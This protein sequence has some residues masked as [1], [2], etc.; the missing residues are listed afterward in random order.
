MGF[1]I[2]S[3]PV[4]ELLRIQELDLRML[5]LSFKRKAGLLVWLGLLCAGLFL[6]LKKGF[7]MCSRP[8]EMLQQGIFSLPVV[9][10]G[11]KLVTVTEVFAFVFVTVCVLTRV[12]SVLNRMWALT[13]TKSSNSLVYKHQC[14]HVA[15]DCVLPP[16]PVC[17]GPS[18]MFL[19]WRRRTSVSLLVQSIIILYPKN[20]LWL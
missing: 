2:D 12:H 19:M 20:C 16:A 10:E 6:S 9:L 14:F 11:S 4:V 17:A 1:V 15:T 7:I 18:F 8:L 13:R 5:F 3:S